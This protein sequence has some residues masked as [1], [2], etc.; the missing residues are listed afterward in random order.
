MIKIADYQA[1]PGIAKCVIDGEADAV[2]SGH[3]CFLCLVA[4]HDL[5]GPCHADGIGATEGAL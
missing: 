1:D 3:S 5:Q 4:A 2:V